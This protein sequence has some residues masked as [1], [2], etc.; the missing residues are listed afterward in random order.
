M[1][2]QINVTQ[3]APTDGTYV[4]QTANSDL[5][6]EQALGALS[7]GILRV[8]TSTGVVTSLSDV[9]PIANGGLNLT[10]L[11]T[12]LQVLRVNAGATALEYAAAAGGAFDA[13]T[14]DAV[15]W[16]DGANASNLW[17]FDVSG[18]DPTILFGDGAFTFTGG[19][20]NAT[21][22]EVA[23]TLNYATNKA[24]SGNDT[25]LVINHTDTASPG[26]SLLADF[27]VAGVSKFAVYNTGNVALVA[28]A[29]LYLDDDTTRGNFIDSDSAGYAM[30]FYNRYDLSRPQF[31]ITGS[32]FQVRSATV[33][34]R[35]AAGAFI[36]WD[37]NTLGEGN[38][39]SYD[40]TLYRGAA[41]VLQLRRTTNV[42]TFNVFGTWTDASNG[43]WLSMGHD[44]T[45]AFITVD[46]NGTGAGNS[47][48][49][50]TPDGTGRVSLETGGLAYAGVLSQSVTAP[51]ISSGFGTTPS[52]SASNGTTA[53]RVG[54]G[55]GGTASSGI[56]ALPTAANGWNA[57]VENLTAVA[58]N[59][60][61]QRTV[62]T[63]SS[64]TT[65]TVQNQTISTGAALAWTASDVLVVHAFAY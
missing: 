44:A 4:T 38:I 42:Q 52:I 14:V 33:G 27:Q 43:K 25:G 24:T 18:T 64:T 9:L 35:V 36:G 6:A 11:G 37:P 41:D 65:V 30:R 61:D 10:A 55:T 40:V 59:R 8:A 58:A 7:D 1:S 15:T 53:F 26:T 39:S 12:A 19:L 54:V 48:L 22:N 63:A 50:L 28:G 2:N 29:N 47:D 3:A 21:G 17:T 16:S 5:S 49:N 57:I 23:F 31:E 62:V 45:D 56:I 51:T 34:I 46:G 20:D 32:M 13:T 60:A